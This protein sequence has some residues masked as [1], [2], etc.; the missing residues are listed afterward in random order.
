MLA[1]SGYELLDT[2]AL[3]MPTD[4]WMLAVRFV[5]SFVAA[6]VVV[7]AFLWFASL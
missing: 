7:K 5:V 3:L 4:V 6:V 1:A 2:W